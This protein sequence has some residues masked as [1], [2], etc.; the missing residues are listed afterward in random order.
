MDKI[1]LFF[2]FAGYE[3]VHLRTAKSPE[4]YFLIISIDSL[5]SD[6]L[7]RPEDIIIG[8]LV[9]ATFFIN[10]RWKFSKDAIL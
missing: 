6:K 4:P 5:S 8:F 1:L 3:L 2:G 10:G 9:K 7:A